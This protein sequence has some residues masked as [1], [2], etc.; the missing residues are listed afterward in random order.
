MQTL[1]V[2]A[3]HLSALQHFL[4]ATAFGLVV[5]TS[6]PAQSRNLA[7]GFTSLPANA[8]ILV[9]PIDV[10]LFSISAGGVSEPRADWTS[11]AQANM[12]KE[13]GRLRDKYRGE[14]VELDESS[15]DEYAELL[16]LH[17]AVARS[18]NLHHGVG[19]MWALPTK[20]GQLDW[21]FGDAL[22]PLKEKSGAN[23]ALFIWIRDS[24]ASAER[25][26]AMVLMAVLGVGLSGGSQQG[27]A[28]LVDLDT[29]RVL[30]FNSLARASGD[31]R[32]PAKAVETVDTL[33]A[34]FP[35]AR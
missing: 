9:T 16:T 4:G 31:L 21:S 35:A 29:G 13:L 34:G 1:T 12:K 25:V 3:G 23:Y 15:A 26:A 22:R 27:Y 10:E 5:A 2:R 11:A 24:Y 8:K 7:P 18:I 14:S 28:S 17:A 19:G 30:W 20:N 33:L 32:E 6:A